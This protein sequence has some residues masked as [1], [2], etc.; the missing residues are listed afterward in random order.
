[1]KTIIIFNLHSMKRERKNF[2]TQEKADAYFKN[3]KAKVSLACPPTDKVFT[4]V[5]EWGNRT[6]VQ[7]MY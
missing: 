1:M 6:M 4:Y 2:E 3:K 5:N 7:K